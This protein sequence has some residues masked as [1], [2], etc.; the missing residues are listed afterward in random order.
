MAGTT[1][2]VRVLVVCMGNICRSPMAEG[3]LRKRLGGQPLPFTVHVESAGTHG[4]HAG[5]APDDRAQAAA[6]R[7]GVNISGLRARAVQAED[8]GEFDLIL[9][10]D[11]DNEAHLREMA[12]DEHR[13]KIRLFLASTD[14]GRRRSVPD[15]Y[16]GGPVGFERVLDLVEEATDDIIRELERIAAALSAHRGS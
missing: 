9:A 12:G 10:M 13:H 16:Y 7:R 8:F 6:R 11:E 5:A 1:T 4:F 3:L 15:P 14:D 2:E